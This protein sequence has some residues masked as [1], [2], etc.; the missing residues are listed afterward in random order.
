MSKGISLG[1]EFV[2]PEGSK[3][4]KRKLAE[5]RELWYG[6]EVVLEVLEVGADTLKLISIDGR[7]SKTISLKELANYLRSTLLES[8]TKCY[9]TQTK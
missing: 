5:P 6:M 8:R 4:L 3:L 1:V 2:V 9:K 7:I